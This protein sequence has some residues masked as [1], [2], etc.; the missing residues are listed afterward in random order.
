MRGVEGPV[1]V[2]RMGGTNRSHARRRYL[3]SRRFHGSR[4]AVV[5]VVGTLLALLVFFALFGVFLTQYVPLWM[6]EN[7]YQFTNQASASFTQ[8]KGAVD[9]QYVLGAPLS[10]GTP[11]TMSSQSIPLFAQPT[12]GSLAFLPSNCP[13]IPAINTVGGQ[14]TK[15]VFQSVELSVGPGGTGPFVQSAPSGTLSMQ[16][17]NRYYSAQTFYF[18]DDAVVQ[19]QGPGQQVL[20]LPP[21]LNVTTIPAANGLTNTTVYASF[22]QLSGSSQ[23][24][25]GPS[26]QQVYSQL[27]TTQRITSNGSAGA[28]F[29]FI[30]EVGTPYPCAWVHYLQQMMSGSGASYLISPSSPPA[31]DCSLGNG[32]AVVVSFSVTNVNYAVLYSS[33]IQVSLGVGGG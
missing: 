2:Y 27:G 32:Q 26:T 11:F 4:R 10:Y 20:V 16:L 22:L 12:Q 9:S 15:C 18:Q 7:E 14:T 28:S 17:P 1:P 23:G 8:F 19:S 33:R 13:S 6:N 5:A 25:N 30:F 29:D 24:L 21:P 31:S 3:R